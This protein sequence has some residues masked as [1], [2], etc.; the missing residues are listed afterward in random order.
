MSRSGFYAF[1]DLPTDTANGYLEDRRTTNIYHLP[2]RGGG[3]GGMYATTDDLQRLWDSF[4]SHE[5]LSERLTREYLQTRCAIS[6]TTGYGCG[7]LK[8][9]DDSMLA[10]EGVDVGVGFSSQ[11]LA[12]GKLIVNVLSNITD[13]AADMRDALH[14]YLEHRLPPNTR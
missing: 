9:L 7:I 13:G 14:R 2:I 10:L 12:A 5:I 8:R 11:Y 4:L 3:D 1:N 6:G